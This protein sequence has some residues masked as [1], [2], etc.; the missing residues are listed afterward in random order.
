[1]S[2]VE[3]HPGGPGVFLRAGGGRNGLA[4]RDRISLLHRI[5]RRGLV[6]LCLLIGNSI[7]NQSVAQET[8]FSPYARA[9]EYCRG[10]VARPIAL[11]QDKRV[12]CLDGVITSDLNVAVAADLADHGVAVVRSSRGERPVST[13]GLNRLLPPMLS[14]RFRTPN[15]KVQATFCSPLR[16]LKRPRSR[17]RAGSR[18]FR[19]IRI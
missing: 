9:A 1:M 15:P 3:P 6:L 11:S 2:C 12:L 14:P 5:S 10:D 19:E 7:A 16:T 18:L 13:G 8:D 4:R 17:C